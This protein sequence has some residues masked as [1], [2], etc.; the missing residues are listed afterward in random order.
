MN[1]SKPFIHRPVFTTLIMITI[2]FFGV[3]S[4][5]RLPV[6]SLPQ[7]QFPTISVNTSYPGATA[8]QISRLITMPLEHKFM[9][10]QGIKI[11]TSENSYESSAITLIFQMNKDI[12][13]AA[14]EVQEAIQKASGELPSNLPSLPSYSKVNPSD[15]PIFFLVVHSPVISAATIYEYAYNFL[16]LQ[17]GAAEGIANIT[18]YG[19]PYAARIEIDP[20]EL[21]AKSITLDEVAKA[22]NLSNTQQPTGKFYSPTNSIPTTL[23]GQLRR[24]EEYN[25]IIIK[26]IDGQPVK[27]KDVGVCKDSLKITKKTLFGLQKNILLVRVQLF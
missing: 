23:D 16:G 25:E 12:N 26:M 27:L 5:S 13:T 15:T 22:V 24:A 10:M 6:A 9:Q 14:E 17:V 18:M 4:Y 1:I 20:E 8:E 2:I 7:I 21:A 19:S 3:L 11:V